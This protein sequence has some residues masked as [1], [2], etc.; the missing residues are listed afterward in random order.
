MRGYKTVVE[1]FVP[2]RYFGADAASS[3]ELPF[4]LWNGKMDDADFGAMNATF[5]TTDMFVTANGLVVKA[6]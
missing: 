5:K 6:K 2:N 1:F 3:A 4:Y